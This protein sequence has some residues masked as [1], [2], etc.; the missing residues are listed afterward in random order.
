MSTV[1]TAQLSSW[2]KVPAPTGEMQAVLDAT[3]EFL[4]ANFDVPADPLTWNHAILLAIKMQAARFLRR[5]GTPEG[6]AQFGDVGVLRVSAFD[7]DV[8]LLLMRYESWG[9]A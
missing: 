6:I 5:Q 2:M 7:A 1:T 3:E 8:K 9:F 4:V